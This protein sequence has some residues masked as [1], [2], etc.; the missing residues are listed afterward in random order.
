[1]IRRFNRYELKYV[2]PVMAAERLIEELREHMPEDVH[3]RGGGYRILSLAG[4]FEPADP[5]SRRLGGIHLRPQH[6]RERR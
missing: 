3:N 5:A 1:M 2:L 4:G 6:D